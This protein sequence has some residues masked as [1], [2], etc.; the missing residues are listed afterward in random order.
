MFLHAVSSSPV[1]RWCKCNT[2]LKSRGICPLKC[3]VF[4]HEMIPHSRANAQRKYGRLR[5]GKRRVFLKKC[6]EA[7]DT[8]GGAGG[9]GNGNPQAVVTQRLGVFFGWKRQLHSILE[10]DRPAFLAD[11]RRNSRPVACLEVCDLHKAIGVPRVLKYARHLVCKAERAVLAAKEI[12]LPHFL[13]TFGTFH[14]R[15]FFYSLV[16]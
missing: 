13:S 7:G 3:M 5:K 12:P 8:A 11:G 4:R 9:S 15:T 2:V 10:H 16:F 6:A 14:N 1:F